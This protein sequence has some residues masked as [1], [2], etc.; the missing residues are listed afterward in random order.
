MP[1]TIGSIKQSN[2]HTHTHYIPYGESASSLAASVGEKE[3]TRISQVARD[4]LAHGVL[5][6]D[7][8][9]RPDPKTRGP[10]EDADFFLKNIVLQM[11][12]RV[13]VRSR[14]HVS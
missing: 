1:P 3:K 2:T 14:K 5:A 8:H 10:A 6:V 7:H 4:A 9:D 13:S 11:R 12:L